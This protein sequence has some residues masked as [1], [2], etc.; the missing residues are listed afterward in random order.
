L[1]DAAKQYIVS[2]M[3]V[4]TIRKWHSYIGVFI[5]P[6][7]L[8]FASTGALQVFS[9]HEAHGDYEPFPLVEKLAS[10]H[11]DQEFKMGHHQ[12]PAAPKDAAGQPAPPKPEA[13]DDDE[14]P[15]V[16]LALKAFFE[17]V[18]ISLA[19]STAFGLWM[20]LKYTRRKRVAW[21]LFIAGAVIPV[22]LLL[23]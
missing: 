21:G 14:T 17:L 16:Q 10:V 9:L 12:A 2:T 22:G 3:N 6:S 15:P 7:V 11:K 4:T 5:A 18:A 23:A 20:G 13:D 8:F 19:L 1:T